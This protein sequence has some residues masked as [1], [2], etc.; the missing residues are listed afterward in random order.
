MKPGPIV[1]HVGPECYSVN[2]LSLNRLDSGASFSY[3]M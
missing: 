3:R 1:E 2:E